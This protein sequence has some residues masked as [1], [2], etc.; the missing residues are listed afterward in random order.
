MPCLIKEELA[1]QHLTQ[2]DLAA[3]CGFSRGYI[4]SI[5]TGK[6]EPSVYRA[7]VIA[8]ALNQRIEKLFPLPLPPQEN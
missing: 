6:Q 8:R 3:R 4:C 2:T 5:T 7:Q 1:R